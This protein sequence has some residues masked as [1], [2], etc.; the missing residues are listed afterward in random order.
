MSAVPASERSIKVEPSSS[1]P[2]LIVEDDAGLREALGDTLRHAGFAVVEAVDGTGA[3]D[4][5]GNTDIS[6]VLTDVKMPRLDGFGLLERIRQLRPEMPVVM[7]SAFGTVSGAVQALRGGAVDY[8]EK[9]FERTD[10]IARVGHHIGSARN[11]DS[12]IVAEDPRMRDALAM[13]ARVAD[14][15][16]TVMICGESG[17][18]KEVIAHYIH[19]HS[20]RRDGPFVAINCAAIPENLLEATL[21]GHEKGAFTGA[22]Q[23]RTGKFEQANQGTLLLDEVTEMDVGLQ[24]KLLR[25]I[26]EREL[27]RVGGTRS[28]KLDVRLIA[29]T[30]RDLVAEVEAGNFREDLYYRLNVV[31]VHL[32]A[33]RER[34]ACL[35]PLSRSLLARSARRMAR[36][37]PEL[38]TAAEQ[39]LAE[40]HWPGNVRELDNL[41]QRALVFCAGPVIEP[42]NLMLEGDLRVPPSSTT[43]ASAVDAPDKA[44]PAGSDLRS[45]E[46]AAILD[47]LQE[48]NGSRQVAA[49]RLGISPRTL[50]Y[51]LARMRDAGIEIPGDRRTR[52][53]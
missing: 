2:V 29:T 32:P 1:A 40:H 19:Q 35:I 18:G 9:P 28:I 31:P 17:T 53:E 21:F 46:Q 43:P 39:R 23:A 16:V 44:E 12:D 4:L 13:A 11:G 20:E 48:A 38:S 37:T 33:L 6:L 22:V 27:E 10:L 5:L 52:D 8:L 3:L 49:K 50:R 30:N 15:D 41:L 36:S 51:K 25:V 14:A 45:Q 7:M 42:S 26:Q 47:S 34:P 24:A